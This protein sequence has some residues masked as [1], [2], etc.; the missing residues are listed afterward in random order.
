MTAIQY[1]SRA[2][3]NCGSPLEK[4]RLAPPWKCWNCSWSTE[5]K[6]RGHVWDGVSQKPGQSTGEHL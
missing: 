4:E 1:W 5:D 6:S 2:C 3:P